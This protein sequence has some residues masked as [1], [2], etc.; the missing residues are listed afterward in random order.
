MCGSGEQTWQHGSGGLEELQAGWRGRA[1]ACPPL[2]RHATATSTQHTHTH[3][4]SRCHPPSPPASA[5]P[6]RS[7]PGAPPAPPGTR[8]R[9]RTRGPG[10]RR[11]RCGEVR[12]GRAGGTCVAGGEGG[13]AGKVLQGALHEAGRRGPPLAA[14]AGPPHGTTEGPA[15]FPCRLVE[16]GKRSPQSPGPRTAAGQAASRGAPPLTSWAACRAAAAPSG[17]PGS[18]RSPPGQQ[19]RVRQLGPASGQLR[20]WTLPPL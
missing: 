1:V 16:P 2:H 17:P 4:H 5:A 9:G 6:R 10:R 3:T 13:Q 7:A 11:G 14:S 20:R 8:R 15:A 12:E 19:T 18:A